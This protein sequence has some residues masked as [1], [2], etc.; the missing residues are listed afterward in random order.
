MKCSTSILEEIIA[1]KRAGKVA[2]AGEELRKGL[3]TDDLQA[4][5]SQDVLPSTS[6]HA[7]SSYVRGISS[8]TLIDLLLNDDH[9]ADYHVISKEYE[10]LKEKVRHN[11]MK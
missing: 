6:S 4:T 7:S 5:F 8:A 11:N 10:K 3:V 1:P 2:S 9:N